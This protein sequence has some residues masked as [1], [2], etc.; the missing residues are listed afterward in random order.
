[1]DVE[2]WLRVCGQ[3]DAALVWAPTSEF[4]GGWPSLSVPSVLE[5][6]L[7]PSAAYLAVGGMGEAG[8]RPVI[9]LGLT[10]CPASECCVY[11]ESTRVR[12]RGSP[13]PPDP[14]PASRS[15]STQHLPAAPTRTQ[16]ARLDR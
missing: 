3:Y 16:C 2:R 13:R 12:A 10:D 1:M 8:P 9:L 14:R 5:G 6:V 11:V 15:M 4:P 7:M